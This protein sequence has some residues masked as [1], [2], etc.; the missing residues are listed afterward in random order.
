VK[1]GHDSHWRCGAARTGVARSLAYVQQHFGSFESQKPEYSKLDAY[2]NIDSGTGKPRGAAY[3]GQRRSGH[4]S[5]CHD[6]VCRLGIHGSCG[7]RTAG[8]T[9]GTDSTS[10]NNAGLPGVG[11]A[12]DAF[13]YGCLPS[14]ES[15]TYERIYEEDV[16]EGAWK[17]PRPCIRL[18]MADQMVP[19][20]KPRRCRSRCRTRPGSQAAPSPRSG[21]LKRDI[22]SN[23]LTV[24]TR[25]GVQNV[26][27]ITQRA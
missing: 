4:G 22:S 2:F 18:A 24:V 7:E 1:H 27:A 16:R 9:G 12:Q 17:L 14:H 13:D 8:R 15:D 11:L 26:D 10:F 21:E 23:R 25:P 6:A 19:R 20:F 5:R 3:L